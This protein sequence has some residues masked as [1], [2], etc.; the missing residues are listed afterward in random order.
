M[1]RSVVQFIHVLTL[2]PSK[3]N[4]LLLELFACVLSTVDVGNISI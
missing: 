2:Q 1:Q 4:C 3:A